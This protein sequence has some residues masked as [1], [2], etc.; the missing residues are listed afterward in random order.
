MKSRFMVFTFAVLLFAPAVF[1]QQQ[2]PGRKVDTAL[3]VYRELIDLP[4]KKVP[5]SL[6]DDARCVAVIPNV[7]K[8]AFVWGGRHGR[9]I[10]SC[11]DQAGQWSPLI[12]VKLSGGSFGFQIGGASADL[13]LFFM[14]E[15]G[16]KSL[17]KSKFVLG[18]DGAVA[19]G[20]L[21][22]TAEIAT[23]IRLSAEIY[24]YAKTRGIFA[25]ISVEGA[26]LAPDKKWIERYYGDRAWPDD[27]LFEQQAPSSPPESARF[28]AA[29]P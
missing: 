21:G 14:T 15:R 6:L 18:G 4:E 8:G 25:G 28:L 7:I 23:D 2:A 19:A 10:M 20:P 13:V 26:R 16:A 27:I 5:R 17:I 1:A 11:R 9:G 3:Q 22:R 12:F 29:L 24:T